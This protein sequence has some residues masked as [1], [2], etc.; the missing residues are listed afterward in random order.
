MLRPWL[1]LASVSFSVTIL[2]PINLAAQSSKD[3]QTLLQLERD[4]CTTTVKGDKT[5]LGRILADEYSGVG[6]RGIKATKADALA[7][8]TAS[9]TTVCNDFDIKVRLYGDTAVVT[10]TGVRS[11]TYQGKPFADLRMYW[12]DTW[13]RRKGQWQ[14]VASQS[15]WADAGQK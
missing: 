3:E 14:C 8:L 1:F 10:G 6:A 11:G 9:P 12:T 5:G 4:W 2:S 13:V 15:T 7:Q